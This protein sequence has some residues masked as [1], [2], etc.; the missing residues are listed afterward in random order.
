[1]AP[2]IRVTSFRHLN[3]DPCAA[4][5]TVNNTLSPLQNV[6]GPPA[7]ISTCWAVAFRAQKNNTV[8][9][10]SKVRIMIKFNDGSPT[11]T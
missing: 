9:S 3:V 5:V 6:V 4:P 7:L 11:D 2:A 1:M 8:F 10:K